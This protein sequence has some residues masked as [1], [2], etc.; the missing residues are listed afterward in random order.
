[1]TF[2]NQ[3]PASGVPAGRFF[4]RLITPPDGLASGGFGELAIKHNAF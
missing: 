1:M 2:E 3:R 4:Y